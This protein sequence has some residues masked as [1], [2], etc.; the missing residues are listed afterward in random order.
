MAGDPESDRESAEIDE[1]DFITGD[2]RWIARRIGQSGGGSTNKAPLMLVGF[3]RADRSDGP[4]LSETL[5][6]GSSVATLPLD[7]F[8]TALEKA[9]LFEERPGK[10]TPDNAKRRGRGRSRRGGGGA[11]RS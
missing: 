3:W 8:P 1:V 6:V 2:E 7:S 9:R 10:G 4:H 11:S 5:L